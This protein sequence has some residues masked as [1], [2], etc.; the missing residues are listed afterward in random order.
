M[1]PVVPQGDLPETV[2]AI[3]FRAPEGRDDVDDIP[4]VVHLD[5][6]GSPIA[7]EFMFE[8]SRDE[9]KVL[10]HEPYLT[11]LIEGGQLTPFSIQSTIKFDK[12][13]ETLNE[14]SHVCTENVA[15]ERQLWWRCDNP[16][17]DS[18]ANSIRMC[19]DCFEILTSQYE[20]EDTSPE[21]N[22]E[23]E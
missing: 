13:Y 18:K 15:H 7:M 17:H 6:D 10:R 9:L 1:R 2:K 21:E 22:D 3:M 23:E 11:V 8:I 20:I 16:A 14:H 5:E 12:K 4:G 19:D